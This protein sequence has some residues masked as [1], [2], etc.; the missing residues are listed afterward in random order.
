MR[1]TNLLILFLLQGLWGFAANDPSWV[2]L[3]RAENLTAKGE[4]SEAMSEVRKARACH[5][6]EALMRY[7]NKLVVENPDKTEYELKKLL[8]KEEQKLKVS[9]NY[10]Q[11]HNIVGDL[12]VKTNFLSEAER[13]YKLVLEQQDFLDYPDEILNVHYKLAELYSVRGDLDLEE[14]TYLK[15]I[16]EFIATKKE[17]YWERIRYNIRQDITL[18]HI[19]KVYRLDNGMKYFNAL[20]NIGRHAAIA[21]KRD[22][23]LFYLGCAAIVWMTHFSDEIRKSQPDFHYTG[24]VNFIN[25]INNPAFKIVLTEDFVFDKL[26]FFIGYNHF[27]NG[28]VQERDHY[29]NLAKSFAAKTGR[30]NA[31]GDF[32]DYLVAHP[33]HVLTYQEILK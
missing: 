7:W 12:Y 20:Y 32:I 1:K 11:Y 8:Q 17:S 24:P 5:I 10:P 14:M 6:D 19:F 28:N 30:E 16:S 29:F 9:D 31:V 13:E 3:K 21:Q 25:Y 23:S 4:Y 33:E 26:M 2:H 15:I 22:E 18:S 27:L